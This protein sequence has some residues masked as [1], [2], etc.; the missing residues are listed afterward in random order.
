MKLEDRLLLEE[1]RRHFFGRCAIGVGQIALASMLNAAETKPAN[2]M[3]EKPPMFPPKAKNVIFLHMAGG[4][5]QLELFDHKPKLNQFD[6]QVAPDE[7]IKGK[8][9]AFMDTFTKNP[10]RL[11]ANRREFRQYGN[12]GFWFSSLLPNIA[13][14]T[15]DLTMIHGISTENFNH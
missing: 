11:L 7:I 5:S 12:S 8:R 4:P 14:V 1:T 6:G 13:T 10:P 9:F 15:D 2:P 3:A